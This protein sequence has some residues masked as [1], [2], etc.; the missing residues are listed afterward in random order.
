[1]WQNI[2]LKSSYWLF[3]VTCCLKY[4][5]FLLH[6]NMGCSVLEPSCLNCSVGLRLCAFAF[7]ACSSGSY[8]LDTNVSD[9]TAKR[10][11]P[12]Q[13]TQVRCV[14]S[15]CSFLAVSRQEK[16]G[17]VTNLDGLCSSWSRFISDGL[18]NIQ[19][20]FALLPCPFY[21]ERSPATRV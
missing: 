1:M 9:E 10:R 19:P 4:Q 11:F 17:I 6:I 3:V 21:S 5:H 14:V 12:T 15:K 13:W 16:W 2:L 8:H 20:A 7:F 18:E